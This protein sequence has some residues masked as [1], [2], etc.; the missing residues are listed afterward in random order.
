MSG[1]TTHQIQRQ[2]DAII[3]VVALTDALLRSGRKA[4]AEEIAAMSEES[5][6]R[7]FA[8]ADRVTGNRAAHVMFSWADARLLLAAV[9]RDCLERLESV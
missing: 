3:A 2:T 1:P 8:I 4:T 7:V 9:L 6:N 5:T